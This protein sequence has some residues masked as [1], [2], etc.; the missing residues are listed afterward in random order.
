MADPTEADAVTNGHQEAR[1]DLLRELVAHL[2]ANRTD[3]RQE[4][5]RTLLDVPLLTAID[6]RRKRRSS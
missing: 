4:W 5:A 6:F 2:R 3:L 1:D